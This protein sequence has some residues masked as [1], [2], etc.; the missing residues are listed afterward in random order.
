M[1]LDFRLTGDLNFDCREVFEE[2]DAKI[3]QKRLY[4][5]VA[6]SILVVDKSQAD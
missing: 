1:R 5:R 2:P 4:I 3:V 6:F